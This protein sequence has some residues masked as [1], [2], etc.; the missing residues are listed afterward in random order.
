MRPGVFLVGSSVA[1]GL[2]GLARPA[3]ADPLLRRNSWTPQTHLDTAVHHLSALPSVGP[4]GGTEVEGR[5]LRGQAASTGPSTLF[6]LGM[7]MGLVL[8]DRLLIPLFAID[9]AW[10]VGR[11]PTVYGAVDGTVFEQRPW[12]AWR[13]DAYFGGVGAR[14]KRRRW[15]FATSL[16]PGVAFT[17][18][19]ARV[20]GDAEERSLSGIDLAVRG[21]LEGCRRLDP[22]Q[23]ACLFL[24]TNLFLERP[25]NGGT[26]GLRWELGP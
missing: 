9:V 7:G 24:G 23:R 21:Q 2:L 13:L 19:E 18:V 11:R 16:Q 10:S 17:F 15:A 14:W 8:R 26:I 12:Q 20:A 3:S 6:G 1:L 5:S 22:E 4:L 25:F